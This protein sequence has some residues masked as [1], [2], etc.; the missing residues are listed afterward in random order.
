MTEALDAS[1]RNVLQPG[2]SEPFD[3]G[4]CALDR[5]SDIR[6][7]HEFRASAPDGR[8]TQADIDRQLPDVA[9]KFAYL[10]QRWLAMVASDAH[11]LYVHHDAFD[12]ADAD[13]LRRL[14]ATLAGQRPG[15]RFDLL[16]LRRT[17]P[18][19]QAAGSLPDNIAWSTVPLRRTAGRARTVPGIALSPAVSPTAAEPSGHA[20]PCDPKDRTAMSSRTPPVPSCCL[21]IT[22]T[23]PFRSPDS[24]PPC[25]AP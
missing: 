10:S 4:A 3:N 18:S 17:P 9:V 12:E 25:P 11:V 20:L 7:F 5:G 15:H 6:F 24:C 2:Q 1:F 16:W 8:L 19:P 21:R 14:R 22:T 23:Q 13:D